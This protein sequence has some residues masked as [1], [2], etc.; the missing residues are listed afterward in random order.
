MDDQTGHE[1][2]AMLALEDLE[3]LH[4]DLE[5][6]GL[7]GLEQGD[8]V[9][10]E[11]RQRMKQLLGGDR[12]GVQ[13]RAQAPCG[14]DSHRAHRIAHEPMQSLLDLRDARLRQRLACARGG[15]A[16]YRFSIAKSRE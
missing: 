13:V 14:L 11:L 12:V 15:Q 9:P 6:L 1:Y 3:S 2:D 10:D 8:K 4:E 16:D 7:T 5:E